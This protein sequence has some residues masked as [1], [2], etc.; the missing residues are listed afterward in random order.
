MTSFSPGGAAAA[1]VGAVTAVAAA[2]ST[3][4]DAVAILR[5]MWCLLIGG[6]RRA[7]GLI[8]GAPCRAPDRGA[9]FSCCKTARSIAKQTVER[10]VPPV[11][12][13]DTNRKR[14]RHTGG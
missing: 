11:N 13:L 1:G 12:P 6:G 2:A 14:Q 5:A 10:P 7:D 4:R 3:A 8:A 9:E